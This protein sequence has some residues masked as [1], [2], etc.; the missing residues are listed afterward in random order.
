M[1]KH[2][3]PFKVITSKIRY[4]FL[5]LELCYLGTGGIVIA[6]AVI[7]WLRDGLNLRSIVVTTNLLL[8]G[9]VVGGVIV[10]STIIS[11]IGYSNPLRRKKWLSL[12][13]VLIVFTMI[14][15]LSL[16]GTI[17]FETLEERRT[18]AQEWSTWN[19]LKKSTFQDQ[20][21]CCGW[22]NATDQAVPS[23]YCSS[24]TLSSKSTQGCIDPLLQTLD[25]I[26]RQ[27][28][29]TLFGFIGIDVFAFFATII[30]IQAINVENRYRKIDE[31]NN[32][33]DRALQRQYV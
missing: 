29:T 5:F 28:F 27:L 32:V 24:T 16:G 12:H 18:Y 22:N 31:K 33:G 13:A 15:L 21:K 25:K 11:L 17:W 23:K 4:S 20:L 3:K 19:P 6:F 26:L 9:F 2:H 7:W 30:L 14:L 1:H 8:S 10:L